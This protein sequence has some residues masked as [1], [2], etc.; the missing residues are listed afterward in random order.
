MEVQ[1]LFPAQMIRNTLGF[2]WSE[3]LAYVVGL[4]TTDGCLVNDGRH[5]SFTSKDIELVNIIAKV[6]SLTNKIGEKRG[7]YNKNLK[8]YQ[9]QFGNVAFYRFLTSVGL[10]PNK[11]KTIG[12]LNVPREYF[13]DFLRGHLDGDGCTY[14]YYDIRWKNSFML[15]TSFLS[16]SVE[17]LKWLKSEIEKECTAIGRISYAGKSTF[18]LRYAKFD[19]LK[20]YSSIY[21]RKNVL[22]LKRKM[23]KFSQAVAVATSRKSTGLNI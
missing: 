5:L 8:Y 17:H 18:Q 19:S 4:I 16:A 1:I 23:V 10:T 12:K 6:L 13:A 9:I 2:N 7:S 3:D 15:Y 20:I 11:T 14:S 21:H 22:C